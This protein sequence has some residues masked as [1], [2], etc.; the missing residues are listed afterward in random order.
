MVYSTDGA[1][2]GKYYIQNRLTID[3]DHISIHIK[4]ALVATEDSRFF[5]HKGLDFISLGRVFVKT[6][7][8]RD[9]R[10]G[11]GSTISQQLAKNLYP[12]RKIGFLSFPVNKIREI[13]I[14][15]R[16]E[17][18]F[19]KEEILG[20]YLN[21][22]PFGEDIY[23]IEVA[24]NRF[25]AKP[26]SSLTPPEA[27]TLVGM[28]AAN[29]AYN[30][31]RHPERSMLRRNVVLDRMQDNGFLSQEETDTYKKAPIK[32]TYTRL[33]SNHGPAPWFM[34]QVRMQAESILKQNPASPYNIYTDGLRI[35]TTIDSRLQSFAVTATKNHLDYLQNLF[36]EH[37]KGRDP[38]QH[39]PEIFNTALRKTD[40]Y[41]LLRDKGLEE[42]AILEE[43]N[44]KVPT[45]IYT[46]EGE[47]QMTISPIDSLK[48]ALRILHTGFVAM[49]PSTGHVLS[50]VG[51]VDFKYFKYDHVTSRRQVGSTFKPIVYA[52]ALNQG[53]DPCEFIS[54]EQRVYEQF[55][56]WEPANSDGEHE[57]YYSMKGGLI[58]S[59]NTIAAEV[60]NKTGVNSVIST[61]RAMGITSP[62]PTVPSIALG[63][64]DISLLEMVTAYTAFA[65][66]G[67]A[68]KPV[69]I[70]KIEDAEGRVL[71]EAEPSGFMEEAFNE[72]T[73]RMM[74]QIL[75][76]VIERGTGSASIAGITCKAITAGR[77][78]P[79]KTMP[80][81]GLSALHQTSSPAPGWAP[82][83][84]AYGSEQRSW[85]R[86]PIR[87]CPYLP[88]SCRKRSRHRPSALFARNSFIPY[89]RTC[90]CGSTVKTIW[91][92]IRPE[93]K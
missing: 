44:K 82:P 26:S 53:Y 76:G 39:N 57:G 35:R 67:R 38:W 33:D 65:N 1:M 10:Q 56:N 49:D 12:R 13:F 59:V 29:T 31:R 66:Y 17:K 21:T 78:V 74:V 8:L 14:A 77:R 45:T 62:I 22:V 54:N 16:L 15:A 75:R 70:L 86:G 41:Q 9:T 84:R 85:D 87:P 46:H 20:L 5:E 64:A 60:I 6:I 2:M 11:G 63:T 28:L 92:T 71:Y 89:R 72:E 79:H 81:A 4:N 55:D 58:H 42:A 51:G 73:A 19:S 88:A 61:A 7:L 32:T 24:A 69:L 18:H 50:W 36:E 25:F 93:R 37:W 23:G 48:R 80:M 47:Q 30:P 83:I 90:W 43:L 91:K 34:E 27:A 3:N 40:R 52:T 68:Q